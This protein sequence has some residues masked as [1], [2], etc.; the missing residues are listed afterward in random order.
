MWLFKGVDFY[1]TIPYP[2]LWFSL[3]FIGQNMNE[4]CIG[5]LERFHVLLRPISKSNKKVHQMTL[6]ELCVNNGTFATEIESI[7]G[8]VY[9]RSSSLHSNCHLSSQNDLAKQIE[10]LVVSIYSTLCPVGLIFRRCLFYLLFRSIFV[11][12]RFIFLIDF[13]FRL[14]FVPMVNLFILFITLHIRTSLIHWTHEANEIHC[15]VWIL[16]SATRINTNC[17]FIYESNIY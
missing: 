4:N 10:W 13:R 6:T 8:G 14:A 11:F 5:H 9:R 7:I 1:R 17:M 16:S 12:H 3:H 15:L 2:Q